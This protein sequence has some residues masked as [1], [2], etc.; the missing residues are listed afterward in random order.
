MMAIGKTSAEGLPMLTRFLG[1][2]VVC[3]C[4]FSFG[5]I[6]VLFF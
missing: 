1:V 6:V 3:V 4:V 5:A 2:I